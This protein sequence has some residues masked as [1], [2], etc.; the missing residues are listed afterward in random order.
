MA[1]AEQVPSLGGPGSKSLCRLYAAASH[2]EWLPYE[3][4]AIFALVN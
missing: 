4:S 3:A 1:P 2:Y